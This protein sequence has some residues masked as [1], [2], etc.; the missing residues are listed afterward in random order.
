V[1]PAQQNPKSPRRPRKRA[2]PLVVLPGDASG[3]AAHKR[4][5]IATAAAELFATHGYPATSVDRIAADAGVSKQTV[6]EYFGSK[7]QLFLAVM[8]AAEDTVLTGLAESL[9]PSID[10]PADLERELVSLGK[11]YLR[12]VLDPGLMALRRLVIGEVPRF[13]QLARAWYE[14]G[15]G[16]ANRQFAARFQELAQAGILK[17]DDPLLAAN[18]FSWLVLGMP[19]N[20]ILFGVADRFS[21]AELDN[22]ARAAARVFMSAYS[23][24]ADRQTPRRGK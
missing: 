16:R 4:Q 15:P 12:G 1:R 18:H 19:Q 9:A 17:V 23:A 21:D 22:F 6:Y 7:E 13:P 2:R 14:A 5:A 3:R 20:M 10:D 8:A 24:G 11:I